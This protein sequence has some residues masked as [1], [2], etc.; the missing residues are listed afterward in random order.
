[1]F[2]DLKKIR[3]IVTKVPGG[4]AAV[5]SRDNARIQQ[6]PQGARRLTTPYA[7]LAL[8]DESADQTVYV[9]VSHGLNVI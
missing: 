4:G 5:S 9:H 6:A 7:C 1:M 3:G 2:Y 8:F